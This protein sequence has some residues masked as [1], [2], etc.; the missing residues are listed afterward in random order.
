M[1]SRKIRKLTRLPVFTPMQ[2]RQI[3]RLVGEALLS[4]QLKKRLLTGDPTICNEFNLS[5][6]V[7]EQ[8]KRIEASTLADFCEQLQQLQDS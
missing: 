7:W 1:Q 2:M 3:N 6:Q 5:P 8:L 4:A